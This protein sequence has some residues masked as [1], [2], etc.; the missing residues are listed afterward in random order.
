MMM[1]MMTKHKK[2]ER[3]WIH[4][5]IL[6]SWWNHQISMY[7]L[8]MRI[9]AS[10]NLMITADW[11]QSSKSIIVFHTEISVDHFCPSSEWMM[12]VMPNWHCQL[13]MAV[14][15]QKIAWIWLL[16]TKEYRIKFMKQETVFVIYWQTIKV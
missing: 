10:L 7:V 6:S 11:M 8:V 4:L 5:L 16:R 9:L 3:F 12:G 13:T 15:P 14:E 1:M 2:R